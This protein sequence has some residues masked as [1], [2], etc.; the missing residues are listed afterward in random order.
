M[1]CTNCGT[2]LNEGT[3]FCTSCGAP[4]AGPASEPEAQSSADVAPESAPMP[5]LASI[6]EPAGETSS[7]IGGWKFIEEDIADKEEVTETAETITK[8]AKK[9]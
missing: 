6:P 5:E 7:I 4:V 1:F 3:K 8:I 9:G 2:Q